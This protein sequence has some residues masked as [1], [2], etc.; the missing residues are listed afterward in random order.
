M[1]NLN[2]LKFHVG[3]DISKL[4]FDA[5]IGFVDYGQKTKLIATH[6]FT[7]SKEGFLALINWVNKKTFTEAPLSYSME[8]T[9][10]YY[11][12]LAYF[13][14]DN[15]LQLHV[16]VPSL[17]KKYIQ[18]IGIKT[19]TDKVDAKSLMLLGLERSLKKW[20]APDKYFYQLRI[21]SRE[22]ESLIKERIQLLN[23][24][25]ASES[26]YDQNE[27]TSLRINKRI[28]ILTEFVSEVELDIKNV[29]VQNTELN[30]KINKIITIPGIGMITVATVIA[31]THGFNLIKNVR[32]LTS[33]AGYDVVLRDSGQH[34]SLGKISKKGNSHIRKAMHLPALTARRMNPNYKEFYD[35]IYNKRNIKM[36]GCVALQ[37]KLLCLIYT[38]WTRDEEFKYPVNSGNHKLETSFGCCAAT[39]KSSATK[40]V[41]LH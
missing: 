7:N 13:L 15:E 12:N 8:A 36:V 18:S 38:L 17:A 6:A 31:E 14:N 27:K 21:L 28:E 39:K 40:N 2:V 35:R 19:K 41:A 24:R 5:A 22:R 29:I 33:Y 26:S 3:I 37:R 4:K 34:K 11:E 23:Q 20:I 1:E 9:G 25:H 10:V 16:L 32:Q 30:K